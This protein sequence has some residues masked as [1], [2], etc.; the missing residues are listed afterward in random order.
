MK[1]I[2]VC[3]GSGSGKGAV[4]RLFSELG[5]PSIDTDALYHE[6]T[7][8]RCALTEALS[9]RFG[10]D[11]LDESGALC[12]PRLA[13]KVFAPG[14][15]DALADLNRIAHAHILA[16]ARVWLAECSAQGL[17][18]ACASPLT[19]HTPS[20]TPVNEPGPATATK[21]SMSRQV[22]PAPVSA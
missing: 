10:E 1:V 14:A 11:V 20:R 7:A 2:G 15:E 19:A 12:R 21:Q 13:K 4:C 5:I 17:P 18:A 9:A 6:M 16:G 22:S 8:K 3:G